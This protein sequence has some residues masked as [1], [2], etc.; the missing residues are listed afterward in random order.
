MMPG[1]SSTHQELSPPS[2]VNPATGGQR[3]SAGLSNR[4]RPPDPQKRRT[5]G[6]L[7]KAAEG[8]IIEPPGKRVHSGQC[9]RAPRGSSLRLAPIWSDDHCLVGWMSIGD[10]AALALAQLAGWLL[11]ES[12][13]PRPSR[14]GHPFRLKPDETA[15]L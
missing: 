13:V 12:G 9:P 2:P 5:P 11:S 3:L 10:A 14:D 8:V 15:F 7:A 1:A 6:T 4:W